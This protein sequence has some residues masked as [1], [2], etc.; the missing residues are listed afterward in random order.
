MK[1][2]ISRAP[3]VAGSPD[4]SA[5]EGVAPEVI[6][7]AVDDA[8]SRAGVVA[9]EVTVVSSQSVTWPNPALGCP[10]R[11]VMYADVITPGYRVVVEAGGT[12]YDYRA[13]QQGHISW[14]EDPPG[15]G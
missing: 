10:R 8:A 7:A 2:G 6:Q 3:G 13:D 9:S 5:G 11:G 14:C 12:R 15:P 1:P 4:A